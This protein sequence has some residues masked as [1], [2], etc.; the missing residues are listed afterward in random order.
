MPSATT[1]CNPSSLTRAVFVLVACGLTTPACVLGAPVPAIHWKFDGDY[2][3]SGSL[4]PSGDAVLTS[5]SGSAAFANAKVGQGL[6]LDNSGS[7]GGTYVGVNYQLPEQGTVMAWY[8]AVPW[9]D[10]Q[11]VFDNSVNADDWEMWIYSNGVLRS[12]IDS[13]S[14]QVTYDLDNLD[15]PN[16]WYHIAYTWDKHDTSS[17]AA[18]LYVN[19][20][21]RSS[22]DIPVW[23]NPGSTFYLGGGNN[24]NTYGRGTWDEVMIFEQRLDQSQIEAYHQPGPVIHWKMNGNLANSGTGGSPY[25]GTLVDGA[26]GTHAYVPGK[27]SQALDLDHP[28]SPASTNGDYVS[29]DYQLA[30]QGTIALWYYAEPWYNYQTIFDNSANAN[31]WEFWV[32]N[33]GLARFRVNSDTGVD[34]DLDNLNGPDDWYH[35]AITWQRDIE[36][37][38]NPSDDTVD[39]QLFVDGVL[40]DTA[41]STWREPGSQFFLAGGRNT[42]GIGAWDEV[43]IWERLLSSAE[44]YRLATIPEPGTFVLLALGGL[45]LLGC[46]WRKRGRTTRP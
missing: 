22:D 12:R 25:D 46:R 3:N 45:G 31:Y 8:Y 40:R 6:D 9:Y 24:G 26:S 29:V 35:F 37:P 16:N 7:T 34:Y 27:F 33:N 42:Y 14:G 13:G 28:S 17:T 23:I 21:L 11:T 19:G 2:A 1:I 4:G 20:Q 32:Y 5:G 30:D 43:L 41:T 36:D 10:Y 38:G 18:N 15:G 44:I 39:L